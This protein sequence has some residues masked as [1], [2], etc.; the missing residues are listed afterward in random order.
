MKTALQYTRAL[1]LPN[2]NNHVY[3]SFAAE[4]FLL[5]RG[6]GISPA[7]LINRLDV[8]RRGVGRMVRDFGVPS[9]P[10]PSIN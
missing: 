4:T 3:V 8:F 1:L 7:R 5:S 2:L 10:T 9:L 6:L